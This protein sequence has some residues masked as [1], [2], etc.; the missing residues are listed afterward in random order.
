MEVTE[1]LSPPIR[2]VMLFKSEVVV[3]TLIVPAFANDR[4]P[5]DK[6]KN[7]INLLFIC[8]FLLFINIDVPHELQLQISIVAT[9]GKNVCQYFH[10]SFFLRALFL[11]IQLHT[12]LL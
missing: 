9:P 8:V 6:I 4:I 10:Q 5:T 12:I 2:S 7:R 1:T 11:K 3:T